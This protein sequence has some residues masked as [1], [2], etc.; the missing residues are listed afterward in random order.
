MHGI[1]NTTSTP[2]GS[3]DF[4]TLCPGADALASVQDRF[5]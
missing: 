5:R 1:N 3:L 4:E 2:L